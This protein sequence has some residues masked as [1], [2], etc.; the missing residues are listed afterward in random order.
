MSLVRE[1]AD[2]LEMT[3]KAI[4]NLWVSQDPTAVVQGTTGAVIAPPTVDWL[5]FCRE[6]TGCTFTVHL[7]VPF[8]QY[9]TGRLY[10]LVEPVAE[11]IENADP[12]FVVTNAAPGLL[13]QGGSQLPTY[14]L[15]VEVG[16]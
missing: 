10:D 8:D 6:P 12:A 3:L 14:A 15:T 2:L 11:A 4:P 9:A 16:R 13:Q 1:A 5:A 7:V